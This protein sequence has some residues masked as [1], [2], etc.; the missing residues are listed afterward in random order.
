MPLRTFE[1]VL[2]GEVTPVMSIHPPV[3]MSLLGPVKASIANIFFID[4]SCP[5]P[6][7]LDEDPAS[8]YATCEA[9]SGS[10]FA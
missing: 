9:L 2:I 5:S 1:L 8:N 3:V 10:G 4:S 6:I 7:T